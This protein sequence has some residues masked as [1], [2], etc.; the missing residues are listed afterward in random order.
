M[1]FELIFLFLGPPRKWGCT[2]Q[3]AILEIKNEDTQARL[4]ETPKIAVVCVSL[5]WSHADPLSA[6]HTAGTEYRKP[7]A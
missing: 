3:G 5:W 2:S 4:I 6:F 7:M 1:L